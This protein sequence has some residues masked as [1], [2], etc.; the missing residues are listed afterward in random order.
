L[1]CF[2]GAACHCFINRQRDT[3]FT[4]L[5][6]ISTSIYDSCA[7]SNVLGQKKAQTRL[8]AI[9]LQFKVVVSAGWVIGSEMALQRIDNGLPITNQELKKE[10]AIGDYPT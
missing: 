4:I 5:I 3:R 10:L 9:A 8:W 6:A 1:D 2:K 7:K